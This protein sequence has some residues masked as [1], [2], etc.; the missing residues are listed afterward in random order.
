MI[1]ESHQ[2]DEIFCQLKQRELLVTALEEFSKAIDYADACGQPR[3]EFAFNT[4]QLR[5]VG[6]NEHEVRF[7]F[8]LG[9]IEPVEE[10]ETRGLKRVFKAAGQLY[11]ARVCYFLTDSGVQIANLIVNGTQQPKSESLPQQQAKT[12]P[13]SFTRE[14]VGAPKWDVRSRTLSVA[15]VVVKTFRF[16]AQNQVAILNAFEEENWS[17]TVYDPL[18]PSDGVEPKRRLH[19]TIKCLNK[20]HVN[21][22]I[23]FSGDGTGQGVCWTWFDLGARVAE[24]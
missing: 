17:P 1:S 15:N 8:H 22:V 16:S 18:T 24:N 21:K 6:L 23:R 14:P 10:V 20:R 7:L 12:D 13:V 5:Q 2:I 4:V 19:D 11:G 9:L 3:E